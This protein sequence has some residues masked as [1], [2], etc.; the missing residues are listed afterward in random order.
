[1]KEGMSIVM[2]L[3]KLRPYHQAGISGSPTAMTAKIKSI[4][5]SK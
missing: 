4:A 2:L 1:M 5:R 3:L